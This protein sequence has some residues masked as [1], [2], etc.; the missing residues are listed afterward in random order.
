MNK[1][2][3]FIGLG[4]MATAIISGILESSFAK[5]V[6]VAGYEIN[7][8]AAK[9]FQ[10]KYPIKLAAT[11]QELV[12]NS[13]IIFL[14]VKPFVIKDVLNNIK[15]S[16]DDK[17]VI[18]SIVAGIAIKT[19]SGIIGEGASII[20]IMPNT[21]ALV[22]SGMSG[23]APNKNVS[24]EDVEYVINLLSSISKVVCLDES[25][26]D[27]VTALSGSGPAF[28]YYLIQQFALSAV[29]EG[30]KPEDALVMSAQ[31]ALGAAKMILETGETPEILIRNVTTPGGTTEVGN[32]VLNSSCIPQIFDEVI[33]KTAQK[34][35]ELGKNC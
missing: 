4:K 22:K 19:I 30:L 29:K 18:V 25:L 16:V 21:P 24:K 6:E 28:Y 9:K 14:C 13:D 23:L 10:E 33:A 34:S 1:K 5:N 32:N 26:L 20:R 35:R 27:A 3:G 11:P 8:E 31:T 17:K 2:I 7:Q 15:T 12:Q